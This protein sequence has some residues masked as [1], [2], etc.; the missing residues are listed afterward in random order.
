MI[1]TWPSNFARTVTDSIRNA[2]GRVITIFVKV[3]GI[4][5]PICTLDPV[6][7]LSTDPFCASCGG[8]YWINTTSSYLCS[9]HIRWRKTDQ[10]LWSP[11]GIVDEGDCKVTI[12]YSGEALNNVI[13][14]DHFL[15][16]DEELY[17]KSYILKGVRTPNR[18]AVTLLQDPDI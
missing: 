7:N 13:N 12:C 9:A 10:P 11:G 2:I 1:I 17:M 8:N 16:D 3:S 15:V 14:S 5:C 4:P 6:T 18:I